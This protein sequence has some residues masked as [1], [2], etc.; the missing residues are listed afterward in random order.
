MTAITQAEADALAA[1][2]VSNTAAAVAAINEA[3]AAA[4]DDSALKTAID[5]QTAALAPAPVAAA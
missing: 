5:A 1:Q 4:I 2:I 3:K